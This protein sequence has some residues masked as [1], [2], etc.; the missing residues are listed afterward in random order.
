MFS[1]I[2]QVFIELLSFSESLATKCASLNNKLCMT[3]PTLIDLNP[4]EFSYLFMISIEKCSDLRDIDVKV[5][6][7]M[8]RINEAKTLI[9][10]VLCDCKCK[11]N[12]KTNNSNQNWNNDTWQCE[13]LKVLYMQK[14]L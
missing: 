3:K 5:F 14:R 7:T 13:C 2:K 6:N 11:S 4:V 1:L 8:T 9:K 10:H 12:S